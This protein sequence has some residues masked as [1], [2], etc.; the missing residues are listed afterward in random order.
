MKQNII[1]KFTILIITKNSK[2]FNEHF[3]EILTNEI[4]KDIWKKR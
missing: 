3:P 2:N 1:Y 4:E